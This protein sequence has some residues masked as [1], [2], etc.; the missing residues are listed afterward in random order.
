MLLVERLGGDFVQE[1]GQRVLVDE[2]V[3]VDSP[4]GDGEQKGGPGDGGDKQR[5]ERVAR[6]EDAQAVA[7]SRAHLA[8]ALARCDRREAA[9]PDA[10]E[11]RRLRTLG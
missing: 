11:T 7:E 5:R 8:V 6:G 4:G 9:G 1:L 3:D 2:V 10:S